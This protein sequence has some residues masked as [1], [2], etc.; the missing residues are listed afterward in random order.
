MTRRA[1]LSE[2]PAETPVIDVRHSKKY[3]REFSSHSG[4][5]TTKPALCQAA[6]Q[7]DPVRVLAFSSGRGSE[8]W[9]AYQRENKRHLPFISALKRV[10]QHSNT[11]H[12]H[13]ILS[14][15]TNRETK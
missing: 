13:H 3:V 10:M 5:D 8:R 14:L 12:A 4:S 7:G 6:I 2:R 9:R 11:E 15:A 1:A